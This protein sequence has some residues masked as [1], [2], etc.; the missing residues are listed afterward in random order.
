MEANEIAPKF[1]AF[2]VKAQGMGM[3]KRGRADMT[4][5]DTE[6]IYDMIRRCYT[7]IELRERLGTGDPESPRMQDSGDGPDLYQ[8]LECWYTF[9]ESNRL[10]LTQPPPERPA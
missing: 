8:I 9:C 10:D 3:F 7:N 4:E 6:V 2:L 1:L 5:P